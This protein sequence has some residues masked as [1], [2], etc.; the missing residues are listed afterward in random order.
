[1]AD[2]T[3]QICGSGDLDELL[4]MGDQPLAEHY[5]NENK[6]LRSASRKTYPLVLIQCTNCSLIQ[7]RN[8]I[9]QRIVFPPGH[10]YSTGNSAVLREHYRKLTHELGEN[11]Q[12]D[13]VV[14]DIG[15]NDG[16][17][18]SCF[19]TSICRVAVEP[20]DQALKCVDKGIVTYQEFFTHDTAMAIKRDLG[21][22]ARVITATNVL[23][24]IPDPHDFLRGVR[25]L[26]HPDGVFITENH[27]VDSV[28]RGLQID[29]I[30]HEHL[31]YFSVE[32]LGYLLA[33]HKLT[34]TEVRSIPTHGGSFRTYA[35]PQRDFRLFQNDAYTATLGLRE[36]LKKI[37]ARGEIVYGIGATTRAT[38][39]MHYA[40]IAPYIKYVCEVPESEKIGMLMPGTSIPIVEDQR[41]LEDNPS[42]ALLFSWHMKD[43]IVPKLRQAGYTGKIIIPLPKVTIDG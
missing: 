2:L 43:H 36:I 32:T 14:V 23:A 41:L 18:L 6:L 11:L 33:K 12:S 34:I 24:H 3:C 27:H 26:L 17:L 21:R 19:D 25:A 28:L 30:Y 39:L 29:T 13:D 20:T 35:R 31:R 15:A 16:T 7:L 37:Q 10:P 40:K 42:H 9:D 1:M 4:D 5:G 38:P 8:S 22:T